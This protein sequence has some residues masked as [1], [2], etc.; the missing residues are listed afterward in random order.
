VGPDYVRPTLAVPTSYKETGTWKTAQPR[1]AASNEPWWQAYGDSTL[2]G[3]MRD[4]EGANQ[5]LR[6]A[7]AQYRAARAAADQARSALF[8]VLGASVSATRARVDSPV[9]A[10]GNAF[11]AGLDA[12]WEPDLW[13]GIRR[14][15][16]AGEETA[17]ASMDDLAAAHLSIQTSLAQDYFELRMTD[18]LRDLYAATT[19]A[20]TRALALTKAQYGAGVALRSDVALAE[21][22]LATAQAQAVD[23]DASRALLEHAIAVLTGRAPAQFALASSDP[24]HAFDAPLPATPTGLPSE[25]LEHRPDIAGA[26]RRAAAAN[27]QIGVARAAYFPSLTLS[28]SGGGASPLMSQLFD[29][30]A[31]VWSIGAVLAETIFDGG[32]RQ[33]RD[34]QAVAAWDAAAAT[35]KQTVLASFQQVE[36]DLANLRILDQEAQYQDQAV[37]AAQLAESLALIQYRAGT[38]TYLSVVT[39]QTLSLTNQ[40]TAVQLRGRQVAASIFLISATGGGWTTN[41]GL[42]PVAPFASSAAS[43]AVPTS[44]SSS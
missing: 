40:R 19:V 9:I 38:T 41:S 30:P 32:A 11:G 6:V 16:E 44:A 37:R 22:Q 35:Y 12:S 42:A 7:E 17:Q 39:A 24:R 3:L 8:P 2:D 23:L 28:A 4:A 31:R 20:Y 15:V 25:L 10:T 27:A 5:D 34:A 21:S 18:R 29:A 26:E 1:P 33:A 36:D 13:G 14:A 43:S